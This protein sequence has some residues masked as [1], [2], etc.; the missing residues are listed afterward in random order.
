MMNVMPI[1]SQVSNV[2]AQAARV[3]KGSE[4]SSRAKAVML[5]RAPS[6]CNQGD[7]IVRYF[8]ET[9]RDSLNSYHNK[10]DNTVEEFNQIQSYGVNPDAGYIDEGDLPSEDDT[11]YERK[12]SVI[13]YLGTTRWNTAALAA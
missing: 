2:T 4:T 8:G 1:S 13:K 6:P 10:N 5:P 9:Q 3:D 12:F 7:N 11:T